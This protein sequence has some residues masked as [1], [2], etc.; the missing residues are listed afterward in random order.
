MHVGDGGVISNNAFTPD[1]PDWVTLFGV[2]GPLL[3]ELLELPELPDI[4]DEEAEDGGDDDGGVFG[5]QGTILDSTT[6]EDADPPPV[7]CNGE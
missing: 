2:D 6:E 4:E 3:V 1:V 7:R 5:A